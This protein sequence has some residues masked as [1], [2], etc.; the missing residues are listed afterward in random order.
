MSVIMTDIQTGKT[1]R[2]WARM[3]G[4]DEQTVMTQLRRRGLKGMSLDSILS[5]EQWA[6]L[7]ANR[8]ATT[9]PGKSNSSIHP[10]A[11][12]RA[13]KAIPPAPA[14]DK[15][16]DW[17][18]PSISTVRAFMLDCIL[19]GIVIGHA[20]LIWYDCADL[21]DVPGQIGGGLA[22]FIIVA[23][24]MLS[25]DPAKNITSQIALCLAF[26]VDLAAWW[27]HFPVFQTYSV[28]DDITKVLCGFLCAMSFG[29][30]LIYRHQK[31][32]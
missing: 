12:K 5:A 23:A 31:N 29:A 30:L 10:Q 25:T 16:S 26:L 14:V 6:A 21:W 24:V 9:K 32:N 3:S 4:R 18:T 13:V 20:G 27:V 15:G 8:A 7:Y 1:V 22:F 11:E 17:Q 28:D 19:I 2:D